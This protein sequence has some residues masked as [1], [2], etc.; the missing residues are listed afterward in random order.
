MKVKVGLRKGF[1]RC[2][3]ETL[4]LRGDGLLAAGVPCSSF[5][6][7]NAYT[8]KRHIDVLGD[9]DK[10]YIRQANC[11]ACRTALLLMLCVIRSVQFSIEQPRSS[12]LYDLPWMKYV[13]EVCNVMG[14]P[15]YKSFL[16]VPQLLDCSC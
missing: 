5:V 12:R 15:V 8:S 1:L 11:V 14:I 6:W 2:I 4:R 16:P 13:T 3:L 7:M 9:Q 10:E